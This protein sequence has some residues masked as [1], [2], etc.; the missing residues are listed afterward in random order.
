[1]I[2]L[3]KK[4][5]I[6]FIV[7]L[8]LIA[9]SI[10][11]I[12][13][14]VIQILKEKNKT[15]EAEIQSLEFYNEY[16]GV[17]K[18]NKFEYASIDE[19]LKII[20]NGTGIIYFGFPSCPWCQAYVPVLDEVAREQNIEKVYYY[21]PKEIRKNNTEEYKKIVA[22]LGDYLEN[23]KDGNKRLYVP[24]V[25]AIK[26]GKVIGENN[27]MSTMSGDNTKEYFTSERRSQLK[28]TL[29]KIISEFKQSCD[30]TSGNKGC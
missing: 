9:I 21:N 11:L 18:E 30:D 16:S 10:C 7:G 17:S 1:M 5:K 28:T 22:V 6:T 4:V 24:H 25:F 15:E 26:E 27:D 14:S 19:I 13:I 12:S 2:K 29:T 3:D 20:D 8:I 23:D